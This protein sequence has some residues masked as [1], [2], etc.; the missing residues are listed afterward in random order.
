LTYFLRH[1]LSRLVSFLNNGLL[2]KWLVYSLLAI[3]FGF[4]LIEDFGVATQVLRGGGSWLQWSEEFSTT[5]DVFAWLGLIIVFELETHLLSDESFEHLAVRWGLNAV[6]LLCYVLLMHTVM[7]RVVSVADFVKAE[8]M[9]EVSSLCQLVEQD[10]IFTENNYYTAID[11]DT[12]LQLAQGEEFYLLEKGVVTDADGYALEAISRW[13][14]IQDVLLW[15]LIVAAIELTLYL[16]TKGVTEGRLLLLANFSRFLYGV[17]FM[18]AGFWLYMG[19]WLWAWDQS[20]WIFGF[21]IIDN[22]LSTWR[23]EI[24]DQKK[25]FQAP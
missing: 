22:N 10:I 20:L 5:L 11:A 25:E 21:W 6:R 24:I 8:R 16:Q 9:H 18:H 13:I 2:I 7:A 15:L 17:L 4:Y 14:D 3:N 12:C 23:E 1:F 19:H